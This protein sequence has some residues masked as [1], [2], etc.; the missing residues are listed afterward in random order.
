MANKA[1]LSVGQGFST[2]PSRRELGVRVFGRSPGV[3]GARGLAPARL[4]GSAGC[5]AFP[6]S[7]RSSCAYALRFCL[8]LYSISVLARLSFSGFGFGSCSPF[9]KSPSGYYYYWVS[10]GVRIGESPLTATPRRDATVPSAALNSISELSPLDPI[11]VL[12]ASSQPQE[13]SPLLTSF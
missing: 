6:L 11:R 1:S 12:N 7:L 9:W 13:H 8:C 3:P 10:V 4:V 5:F 2:L